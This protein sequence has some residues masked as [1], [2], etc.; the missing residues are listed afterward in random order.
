LFYD[1]CTGAGVY[2]SKVLDIPLFRSSES[3]QVG[4]EVFKAAVGA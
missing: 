2:L 1:V 4:F 3:E